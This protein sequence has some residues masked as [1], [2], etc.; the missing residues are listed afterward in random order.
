MGLKITGLDKV[1]KNL[2]RTEA[3][4]KAGSLAGLREAAQIIVEEA[5]A[6]APIDTGDLENAIVASETRERN[7]LGQFGQVQVQVGVDVSRLNLEAHDGYDYS[8]KMHEDPNYNL[9]PLS[10]A[11]QDG[12]SHTVGYKYLTRALKE[13]S[14][15]ARAVIVAA[16]KGAIR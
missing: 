14:K 10:Q 12:S 11:K 15:E 7:S 5:R 2:A 1:L 16:V 3:R 4:T 9:G 13:K 8:I 6:N